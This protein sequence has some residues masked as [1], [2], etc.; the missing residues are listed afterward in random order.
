MAFRLRVPL[1]LVFAAVTVFF[2]WQMSMLRPDAS[3]E[4][5]IPTSHPYI[6]N[7]L[8]NRADRPIFVM[9]NEAGTVTDLQVAFPDRAIIDASDLQSK[10]RD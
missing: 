7:Y 6:Q 4:K 2:A 8:R 1:L 3:F 9:A 5:M 10:C